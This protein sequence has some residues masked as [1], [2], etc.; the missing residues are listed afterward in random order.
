MTHILQ[1][2]TSVL[3][4]ELRIEWIYS[5]AV[6]RAETIERLADNFV[7]NLRA[8]T[9]FKEGSLDTIHALDFPHS[10]L[11]QDDLQT[12]FRGGS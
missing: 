2:L 6:H 7:A 9:S 5:R 1:I 11:D 8:L 3:D 4:G 12:L 10:G